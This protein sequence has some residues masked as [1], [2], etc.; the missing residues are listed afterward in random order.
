MSNL[1]S[2]LR[3]LIKEI[4]SKSDLASVTPGTIRTSLEAI[5]TAQRLAG[6]PADRTKHLP[7]D[8]DLNA[9]KKEVKALIKECYDE[10][11]SSGGVDGGS[12]ATAGSPTPR[13][14][15]EIAVK[16]EPNA[17]GLPVPSNSPPAKYTAPPGGLALPGMGGVRG[18]HP[19]PTA[20]TS[21]ASP[22]PARPNGASPSTQMESDAALAARLAREYA[23]ET[24]MRGTRGSSNGSSSGKKRKAGKSSSSKRSVGVDEIDSEEDSDV[25]S[26]QPTSSSAKKTK[27]VKKR[28]NADGTPRAPNLNNPFN[29]PLLLS[30]QM[31][32]VCGATEL[33]RHGV[34]K[35]L[36]VYI[37]ARDLQNPNN[38]RQILCDEALKALFGKSMVDSFE[39]AKLI[40]S[41]VRKKEDVI[42]GQ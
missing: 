40:S 20:S 3:P 2:S 24:S 22:P 14:K 5:Q 1:P 38:K 21:A 37:K 29:R 25:D 15:E 6:P 32:E 36:W 17:T 4:L 42:G 26:S 35:A 16:S 39:M 33:P 13:V 28:T 18:S 19:P 41:H 23:S 31:A 10:V 27:T 11:T 7:A 9:H 34:T 12:S 8:F 30:P